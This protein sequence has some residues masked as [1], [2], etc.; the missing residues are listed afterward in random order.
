MMC[1]SS[2][3]DFWL[4]LWY[5]QTCLALIKLKLYTSIELWDQVC[6][7]LSASWRCSCIN[8]AEIVNLYRTMR[9]SLSVA[10]WRCYPGTPVSSNNNNERQHIIQRSWLILFMNLCT[11]VQ[12]WFLKQCIWDKLTYFNRKTDKSLHTIRYTKMV[13]NNKY[14]RLNSVTWMCRQLYSCLI[15]TISA[16]TREQFLKILIV[17]NT[18]RL[19]Y[20]PF[21]SSKYVLS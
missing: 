1:P 19:Y 15:S 12:K 2:V 20:I 21:D 9:S 5:L 10:S 17:R 4:P 11:D 8:Q 13:I 7:L 6:Q 3:Y 18:I 16:V 14:V